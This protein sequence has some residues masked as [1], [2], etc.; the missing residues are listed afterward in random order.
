MPH[1]MNPTSLT[2]WKV[3]EDGKSSAHAACDES[4]VT[5]ILEGEGERQIVSPRCMQ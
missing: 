4:D 2:A 1:V 5:H 3:K